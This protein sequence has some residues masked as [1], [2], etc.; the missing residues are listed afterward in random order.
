VFTFLNSKWIMPGK[1]WR[2][3]IE[4]STE[5][6]TGKRQRPCAGGGKFLKKKKEI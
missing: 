4:K 1:P 5:K 6:S 3:S 2:K